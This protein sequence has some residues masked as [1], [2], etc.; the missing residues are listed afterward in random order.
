[1]AVVEYGLSVADT[2]AL[3]AVAAALFRY[4]KHKEFPAFT[5]YVC[6]SAISSVAQLVLS[7]VVSPLSY[8]YVY[9]ATQVLEYALVFCVVNEVFDS[10][11]DRVKWLTPG[12]K[13]V[14]IRVAMVAAVVAI[15]ASLTPPTSRYPVMEAITSLQRG[16][17]LAIFAF[18][19][20]FVIFA[21]AY[22]IE[23]FRRDSG[24]AMGM[25]L[26]YSFRSLWPS[27]D[28]YLSGYPEQRLYGTVVPL[29]NLLGT[30]VW[31]FVFV[32]GGGGRPA[33]TRKS[34]AV[35]GR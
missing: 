31:L 4:G 18:M 34:L 16:L 29:L 9:W 33:T 28:A 12:G 20:T 14:L 22:S 10:L 23:W 15:A 2:V 24:I 3:I 19:A 7:R 25:F 17:G 32:K 8:F 1:M 30:L 27:V 26:A 6:F 21:R 11:T 35:V 13:K 5:S